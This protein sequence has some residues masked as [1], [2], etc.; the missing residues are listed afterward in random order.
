[1]EK[2]TTGITRVRRVKFHRIFFILSFWA[3][4]LSCLPPG[5]AGAAGPGYGGTLTFGSENDFRGFDPL[6]IN[7]LS[8]CAAIASSTIHERLFDADA[9]GNLIPALA[10]SAAPSKDGRKWTITLRQ[11]VTFHDGTPFNADAVV[12]N[13]SRLLNPENRFRGRS[14]IAPVR[15]VEK[16]DEYTVQFN[17]SHAWLPFP[18]ILTDT[19]ALYAH[20]ISPRALKDDTQS[21]AP[22]GTGPFMFQE[23]KSGDRFVV[24]KNLN[25][26]QKEKPYL[27]KII[28]KSVPDHQTRFASLESGQMDVIYMDRGHIIKRARD[29]A[30]LV[31]YQG[32]S[33]GAETAFLNTTKPPLDDPGVRRAIAHAW[34]QA[35]YVDMSYKNSIPL[36]RHPFGEGLPCGD[37][38]YR[39]HDPEKARSLI[40]QYGKPV[41]IECIHTN[42]KRGREFGLMLQQFCKKIGVTV[43]TKG[44]DISP[45]VKQVFSKNYHVSS[46]RIPPMTDFGPYLY[47]YFY[48]ESRI[49]ATGYN[50]P[51]MDELLLAQQTETD[52]EKRREILCSI[53]ALLNTD[54][55][56]LYRGGRRVHIIAKKGLMGIPEIRN[57]V[58]DIS[59][60][61]IE[62]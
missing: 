42:T 38:G 30:S 19:R 62:K 35:V 1:M 3:C 37:A 56:L 44:M 32:D 47:K 4:L 18:K 24:K 60:A 53:T 6:K 20:I 28:F 22:V 11:G 51:E 26:R 48:S 33:S 7:G 40:E 58:V 59:G 45:I 52:P 10:L 46:W 31:H 8:I 50:N 55:P 34:N 49:N 5:P 23:W 41:E 13:W 2:N 21:R 54:V 9:K 39:A 25:Y 36:A 17:L 43:K 27:D 12:C 16:V 29:N 61:W 14:S 57:G 15:S